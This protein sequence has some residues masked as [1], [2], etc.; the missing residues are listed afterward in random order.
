VTSRAPRPSRLQ[1]RAARAITWWYLDSYFETPDDVGV[2]AMFCRHERVGYFSVEAKALAAGDGDALFG[3]LV[4]MTMFQR[5]SDAQIIRVLRSIGERDARV[6]TG[7]TGLLRLAE[8]TGCPSTRDL[9]AL[10]EQCDLSKH[11]ISKRGT[12]GTHPEITCH[13]KRHTELLKRY[14]HFGKVPTSA[15]LAL[16][17]NGVGSLSELRERILADSGCPRVR[18]VALEDAVSQSWRVSEKISAMF[19]SAV[20][21]HDLSGQLAPWSEGLTLRTS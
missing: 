2:P 1:Y 20:T 6:M 3:L 8:S 5:R 13:L 7:A 4:T 12:C 16:R 9:G 19:L 17:A 11:P 15:A 14:G 21:N 18:A 10:K